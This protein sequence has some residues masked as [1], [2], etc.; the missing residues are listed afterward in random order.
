MNQWP[1]SR[2]LLT[3]ALFAGLLPRLTLGSEPAESPEEVAIRAVSARQ[4]GDWPEF[5][6]M[7]DPEYLGTFMIDYTLCTLSGDGLEASREILGGSPA[8]MPH[9]DLFARVCAYS[10]QKEAEEHRQ[11]IKASKMKLL[12]TVAEGDTTHVV[13]R[14]IAPAEIGRR[15]FIATVSMVSAH[16]RYF[17]IPDFDASDILNKLGLCAN[18]GR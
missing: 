16:S 1:K 11:I 12:G 3:A 9:R 15:S 2:S 14:M 4:Q 18:D 10:F 7:C 6:S 5:A 17:I 8:G 13:Y